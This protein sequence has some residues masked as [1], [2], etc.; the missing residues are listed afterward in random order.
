MFKLIVCAAII[1]GCTTIGFTKAS[2]Y[3]DRVK[4]LQDMIDA[5]KLLETDI[6]YRREPLPAALVRIGEAR[7]GLAA[8]LFTEVGV[9]LSGSFCKDPGD[10]WRMATN[11][12]YAKGCL[13][14]E[15]KAI[16]TDMGQQIGK[17]DGSG[18]ESIFL[19]TGIKLAGQYEKAGYEADLKGKLYKAM[20]IVI[21]FV[22]VIILI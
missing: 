5:L 21:G 15:D 9:M 13:S 14:D 8:E 10:C 18:Q 20:G 11:D 3:Y 6:R 1:A 19:Y 22:I 4:Q 17:S 16:I 7:Q 12:V 2:V